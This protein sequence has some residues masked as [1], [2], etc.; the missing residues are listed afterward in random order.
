MP[1][2]V[3]DFIGQYYGLIELFGVYGLVLFFVGREAWRYRPSKLREM[4]EADERR[5]NE[6]VRPERPPPKIA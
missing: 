4:R 6:A 2:S 3:S 1:T 5:A